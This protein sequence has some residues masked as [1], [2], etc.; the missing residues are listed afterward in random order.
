MSITY[1]NIK[2]INETL[3]KTNIKGKD[4]IEVNERVKAFR[5]LFPNGRIETEL[6]RLE[7]G[8]CTMKSAVYDD[9]GKL[10]ATGMAEEK[11][12]SSYINKTS[13]IENCETSAVGRALGF[14]GIGI[15]TSIASADEVNTAINRQKPSNEERNYSNEITTYANLLAKNSDKT[16][17]EWRKAA[18]DKY[19]TEQGQADCLIKWWNKQKDKA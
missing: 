1:E 4:Y 5:Q 11:E 12:S 13:Y 18:A 7:N 14:V 15:D 10:L 19:R 6:I 3:A 8:V 17:D 9:E 16:A 2:K